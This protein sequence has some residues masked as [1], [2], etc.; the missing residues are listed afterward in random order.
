MAVIRRIFR[1]SLAA[2]I[3]PSRMGLAV[4]GSPNCALLM[5]IPTGIDRVIERV[6]RIEP[7]I[8]VDAIADPEG[9]RHGRHSE[10]TGRD[11]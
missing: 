4:I 5:V 10:K 3:A 1:T 9:A 2:S 8:G 6:D 11:R 7:E